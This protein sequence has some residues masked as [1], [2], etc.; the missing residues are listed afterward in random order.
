MTDRAIHARGFTLLE[1]IVAVTIIGMTMIPLM[2]FMSQSA[3]QLTAA[4]QSNS[5]STIALDAA[6]FMETVNPMIDGT[7]ATTMGDVR[8]SWSS[9]PLVEPNTTVRPGVGLASYAIGFYRVN[10]QVARGAQDPWFDFDMRKV[11]Y[12]R[13]T[14]NDPFAGDPNEATQ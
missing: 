13:I 3:L 4:G 11:G 1:A 14:V 9:Q 5:R 12:R 10:V 2:S 8:I 7:G 6:A